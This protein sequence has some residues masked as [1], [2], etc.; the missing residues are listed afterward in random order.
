VY[1]TGFFLGR[2]NLKATLV[3]TPTDIP[4]TFEKGM[5]DK[6]DLDL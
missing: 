2:E 6:R 5:L 1:F 3:Q 4:L